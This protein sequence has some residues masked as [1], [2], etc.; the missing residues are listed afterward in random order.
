MM[1]ASAATGRRPSCRPAVA[2]TCTCDMRV[3]SDCVRGMKG[4]NVKDGRHMMYPQRT[5]LLCV[6]GM[7]TRLA[8]QATA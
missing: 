3:C 4:M 8:C 6:H 2:G 7:N 5:C 1:A